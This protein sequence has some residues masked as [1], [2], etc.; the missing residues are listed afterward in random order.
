MK[1]NWHHFKQVLEILGYTQ[2]NTDSD[3]YLYF[4]HPDMGKVMIEKH[5]RMPEDKTS[6]Y[7]RVMK[8]PHPYF[9]PIYKKCKKTPA[10]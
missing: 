7:L 9:E 8:L 1:P 10:S 5:N 2:S 3:G 6:K 4:A